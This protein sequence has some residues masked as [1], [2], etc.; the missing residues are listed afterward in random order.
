MGLCASARADDAVTAGVALDRMSSE[1]FGSYIAGIIEGLAQSR[2]EKDGN[3]TG[4][5]CIYDWY[6]ADGTEANLAVLAAFTKYPDYGPGAVM[7]GLIRK[8]CPS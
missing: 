6:Y 2:Y 7:S 3:A 1:E 4:M 5:R 8:E